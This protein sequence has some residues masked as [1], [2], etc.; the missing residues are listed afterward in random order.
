MTPRIKKPE[1]LTLDQRLEAAKLLKEQ[2]AQMQEDLDSMTKPRLGP[3]GE[4]IQDGRILS[5]LDMRRLRQDIIDRRLEAIALEGS[6]QDNNMGQLRRRLD[7]LRRR[8]EQLEQLVRL[9][10]LTMPGYRER[11]P[12]APA[13]KADV[14]EVGAGDVAAVEAPVIED[15]GDVAAVVEVAPPPKAARAPKPKTPRGK[16]AVVAP[17]GAPPPDVYEPRHKM[18]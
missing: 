8:N 1:A 6:A 16:A 12:D 11:E 18:C 15:P 14:G 10:G 5:A 13:A 17:K 2:A 4:V 9:H 3:N 7:Q